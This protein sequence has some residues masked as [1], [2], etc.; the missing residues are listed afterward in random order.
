MSAVCNYYVKMSHVCIYYVKPL[1]PAMLCKICCFSETKH[2]P[3]M[4]FWYNSIFNSIQIPTREGWPLFKL[5][6]SCHCQK[7]ESAHFQ[8]PKNG[9]NPKADHFFTPTS[10]QNGGLDICFMCLELIL[11]NWTSFLECKKGQ[12][13]DQA[14][15]M[16][17]F[18]CNFARNKCHA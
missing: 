10:P 16:P 6:K 4:Q 11:N 9:T 3:W 15:K 8:V 2:L 13:G 17:D 7:A 1:P 12:N 18:F 14:R 5:S